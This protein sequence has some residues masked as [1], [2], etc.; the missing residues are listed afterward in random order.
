MEL[1]TI[2][3]VS[4]LFGISTRTLRY[5]EKIGLINPMKKV[6][7]AY[8]VYDADAVMRLRRIIVLRKL[9]I[10][11]RQIAEILKSADARI[12]IETLE[13]NLAE[14]EDEIA[15]LATIRRVIEVFIERLNY[16]GMK[17]ALP[18]DENLLEVVDALTV[19]KINFKEEKSMNELSQANEKLTNLTDVRII[20]LPPMTVAAASGIGEDSEGKA[21]DIIN[22]FVRESNLLKIK[23]DIRHFGFD[24]S[25]GQTGVGEPSRKY[26]MWVTIPEDMDVPEPLIK[27]TFSGGLYAAHMIMMGNFDHWKLL[28]DWVA[29]NDK[30][31]NDWRTVRCSPCEDDMDRCMEEQLN[32]WGNLQNPEFNLS[33]MQLD[34]LFPVRLKNCF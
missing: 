7:F 30:Y 28:H 11:L 2:S 31:E 27:R 33:D 8:R 29:E 15:A 6:D 19:S 23:P 21:S 22:R 25:A 18:D 32:F 4:R 9:R 20:Y 13:H 12:A 26:Q 17:F 10:P 3:E 14:I 34:L 1:Q 16:G 24:C 5:Y